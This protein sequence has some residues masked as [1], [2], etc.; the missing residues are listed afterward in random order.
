[1]VVVT[2]ENLIGEYDC[3]INKNFLLYILHFLTILKQNLPNFAIILPLRNNFI[4]FE[5]TAK[6]I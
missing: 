3:H 5:L 4:K 2:K 1:M 6:F